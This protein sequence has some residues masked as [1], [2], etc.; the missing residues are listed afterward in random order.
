M[1]I[2]MNIPL[3]VDSGVSIPLQVGE[4]VVTEPIVD[5][6]LTISGAAADAKVTGDAIDELKSAID[7]IGGSLSDTAIQLLETILTAALYTSDQS[8]NIDALI[9]ELQGG[10]G[11]GISISFAG[12]T[13]TISNLAGTGISYSGTTATIGGN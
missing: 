3:S 8:D 5:P 6:T 1:S 10:G 12:T 11:E 4:A 7:D 13:A 2:P 9:E